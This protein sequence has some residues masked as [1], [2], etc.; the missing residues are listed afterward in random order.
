[1]KIIC[2]DCNQELDDI[3]FPKIK[4]KFGF[5]KRCKRC[6]NERKYKNT[7][8]RKVKLGLR[9][10][11]FPDSFS[12]KLL[13]DGKK[14]CPT[15]KQ[16]LSLDKFSTMKVRNG[17]ASHC[18]ECNS[19]WSKNYTKTEKGQLQ[20]HQTYQRNK[21]VLL[22]FKLLRTFGI[23]LDQYNRQLTEQNGKCII[24]GKTPEENGKRLAVD[25]NHTTGINRDLLCNNCNVTIGFIEKNDL[26]TDRLKWYLE[27]HNIN[28]KKKE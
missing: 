26:D 20:R 14:Y 18:R 3:F 10:K 9:V 5:S 12:R 21:E 13:E 17:I 22:N 1:M 28:L 16:I 25:H 15:C 23:T 6:S 4:T 19:N 27:R 11:T 24:C 7:R 8:E 2:I